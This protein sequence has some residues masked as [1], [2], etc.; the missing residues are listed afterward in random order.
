MSDTCHCTHDLWEHYQDETWD[1]IIW[2]KCNADNCNC[3][4]FHHEAD[5]EL[6]HHEAS[7]RTAE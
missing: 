5:C 1:D 4:E 3:T 7:A 2:S 6:P